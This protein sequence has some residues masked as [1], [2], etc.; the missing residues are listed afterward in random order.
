MQLLTFTFTDLNIGLLCVQNPYHCGC[1]R[2]LP[3]VS[4]WIL[5][6]WD[7]TPSGKILEQLRCKWCIIFL[8]AFGTVNSRLLD[9]EDWMDCTV[10]CLV[11][12][13][14]KI[15]LKIYIEAYIV[16]FTP[17]NPSYTAWIPHCFWLQYPSYSGCLLSIYHRRI[18]PVQ[19][20]R[21]TQ[22]DSCDCNCDCWVHF[23]LRNALHLRS[24]DYA[25]SLGV[26]TGQF[27]LKLWTKFKLVL[28]DDVS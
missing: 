16:E 25:N 20:N 17:I 11:D 21:W 19:H 10:L 13:Y 26:W 7:I 8:S 2:E 3:T 6:T 23:L 28:C 24:T 4:G 14:S 18:K 5:S 27:A 15:V 9:C 22:I 1:K 12:R